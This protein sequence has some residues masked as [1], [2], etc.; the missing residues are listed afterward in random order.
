MNVLFVDDNVLVLSGLRR[1]LYPH[2][3]AFTSHFASTVADA[4]ETLAEGDFNVIVS[5]MRMPDMDGAELLRQVAE[6]YPATLR[7]ILSGQ[8]GEDAAL[9]AVAVA[10]QFLSKPCPIETLVEA[11]QRGA[12]QREVENVGGLA[13]LV[14][15]VGALPV[16]PS[17]FVT[18]GEVM[19]DPNA[20][21]SAVAAVL[22]RSPLVV[23]KLLQLVN[24][25]F[26]SAPQRIIGLEAAI[27]RLGLRIVRAVVITEGVFES[28]GAGVYSV[29]QQKRFLD[30]ASTAM[31]A[32]Q[33]MAAAG[34]ARD[35]ALTAALLAHIGVP[36]LASVAPE[37]AIRVRDAVAAGAQL[38][39]CE[40][41]ITGTTHAAFAAHILS[42]WNLPTDVVDAVAHHHDLPTSWDP[43]AMVHFAWALAEH[44]PVD[45]DLARAIG[46]P[47]PG[48]AMLQ[49]LRDARG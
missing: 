39:D 9:R 34:P 43:A 11:I 7:I 22:Q 38:A 2:R 25:S 12:A 5:D 45:L 46:A 14:G 18:L 16:A 1:A 4:L 15:R 6:L 40:Q 33:A 31:A 48:I 21:A 19:A 13:A 23:A 3:A 26:F 36:L 17:L 35:T 32:V 24:S 49:E 27:A 42:L 47:P 41:A 44:R 28:G 10:H 37:L 29:E 20:D 30:E 8:T